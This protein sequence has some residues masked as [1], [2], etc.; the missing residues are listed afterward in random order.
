MSVLD[1]PDQDFPAPKPIK[2]K[3]LHFAAW[4]MM[5]VR[6]R[7]VGKR[8]R[9]VHTKKFR[10]VGG[11]TLRYMLSLPID[12]KF[13]DLPQEGIITQ[14]VVGKNERVTYLFKRVAGGVT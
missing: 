9:N 8:A 11:A 5:E 6:E 4:D 3:P 14:K 10:I 2:A 1:H 13:N 12:T 7:G